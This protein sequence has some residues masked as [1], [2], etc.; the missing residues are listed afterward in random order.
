MLLFNQKDINREINQQLVIYISTLIGERH[1]MPPHTCG[2]C[3]KSYICHGSLKRGMR[4]KH[5]TDESEEKVI[6]RSK[7]NDRLGNVI[8]MYVD[9]FLDVTNI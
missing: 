3:W 1:K 2:T 4:T 7:E 6:E 8:C 5:R 9:K